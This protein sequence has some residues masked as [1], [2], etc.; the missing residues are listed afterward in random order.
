MIEIGYN[1]RVTVAVQTPT[2]SEYRRNF[3]TIEEASRYRDHM[4]HVRGYVAA[5]QAP[6]NDT[7]YV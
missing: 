5:I 1:Q 2:G 4:I 6:I 7:R 3:A